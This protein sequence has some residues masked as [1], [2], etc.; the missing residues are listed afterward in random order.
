M[1]RKEYAAILNSSI[2]MVERNVYGAW[3]I[4][5]EIGMRQYIGYS[6]RDA[7][8]MYRE[9]VARKKIVT[10]PGVIYVQ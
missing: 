1:N 6:R 3:I 8:R 4:R 10:K 9:E 2:W 7:E 5:G